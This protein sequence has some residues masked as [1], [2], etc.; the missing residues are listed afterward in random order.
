[1]DERPQRCVHDVG[2]LPDGPID[3]SEH[4]LTFWEWRIDAMIRL[5]FKAGI[6]VDFAELRRA[7]EDMPADTYGELSYY[8]RWSKAA[9]ALLVEKGVLSQAE[10][11]ARVDEL[12]LENAGS[13]ER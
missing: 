2:G 8:E 4:E 13:S 3:R 7:I 1:M 9:A 12:I 5:M 11:D 10:I 6:L